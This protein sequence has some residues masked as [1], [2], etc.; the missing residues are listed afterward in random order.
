V[1]KRVLD[2]LDEIAGL[3]DPRAR[4][5]GLTGDLVGLWRYR[6]G[7]YRVLVEILDAELIIVA[8]DVDH[9]S[10]VYDR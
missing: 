5:K 3:E 2:Y 6:V 7:D 1:A 4:G 10:R 9:R 8:L